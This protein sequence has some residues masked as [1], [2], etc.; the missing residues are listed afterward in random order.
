MA[1]SSALPE[2]FNFLG[3]DVLD[4]STEEEARLWAAWARNLVRGSQEETTRKIGENL[5]DREAVNALLDAHEALVAE[6]ERLEAIAAARREDDEW[7]RL[8][9]LLLG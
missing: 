1:T 2:T 6:T 4:V 5:S 7:A 3:G 9:A 8:R